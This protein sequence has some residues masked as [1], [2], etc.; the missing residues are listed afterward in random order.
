M[1]SNDE[2]YM[3]IVTNLAK[4]CHIKSYLLGIDVLPRQQLVFSLAD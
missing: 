2:L 4:E 3:L 1:Y